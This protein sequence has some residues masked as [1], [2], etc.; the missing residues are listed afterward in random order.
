MA[1]SF[2]WWYPVG[3]Q[4]QEGGAAFRVWAVNHQEVLVRINNAKEH[5]LAPEASGFFSGFVPD[6]RTGSTYNFVLGDKGVFPDPASRFQPEG[7]HGPSQLID[8]TKFSWT[9]HD[10][11]GIHLPGQVIY[12]LHIGTFTREGTW[13]SAI[14]QLSEL[15]S[16][17]ITAIEIM[18][19]NEYAGTFGWGYDG[20]DLY[21]PT[22][23]YG[24][25]DDFR[26][27]VNAAHS[28]G[29]AVLLDVVYNHVGPD[30]NYLAMFSDDYFT[31]EHK[32]DWGEAINFHGK[33]C[34]PVRRFYA[35]NAAYWIKEY[36][37][38]GLRL[39]ATDAIYDSSDPHILADI[40]REARRA[41]APRSIVVVA[42]NEPQHTKLI[43]PVAEGGYGLD[44]LWNDD[45]HHSLIVATI[46]I[47]EGY[48]MDYLGTPQETL[49]CLKYGFLYQGQWYKWQKK[50]RGT[51]TLGTTPSAM[52]TY[53]QNH[54]QIANSG[55]GLRLQ[56][57]TTYGRYKAATAV[58]LL[59][60]GTPMLFQGQEFA[61]SAPFLFFADHEPKLAEL[62]RKGR[63]E[64]LRQWRSLSTC[65][66]AFD[67]PG[68]RE[69]F[70]KCKLDFSEREKHAEV[71]SLHRDLLKLRK[72]EPVFSRQ[73][74]QFDGAILGPE[75]CVFR[76]F[77][78]DFRNDRLLLVNFGPQLFLDPAPVPLLGP[79]EN[80]EWSVLWSSEDPKYGGNGTAPLDSNLNWIIPAH[81][82]VVLQPVSKT[83]GAPIHD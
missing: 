25:P 10:W 49:S 1:L 34:G 72:T 44:G 22:R 5:R 58:C 2:P 51:S 64:F 77:S 66:L 41:A 71:Y 65:E 4:L 69:T 60:P 67:D 38:D 15:A 47:R 59:G 7:P 23:N 82:A 30:G 80:A 29:I 17:G 33:N 75:T 68:S 52:V 16:L 26:S 3:G 79:P 74:R 13:C 42:E 32:T 73:T 19:V 18:P 55:R 43:R 8:P 12:E 9:D 20:V 46:G 45:F 54:D 36:H 35:A 28:H 70:E 53:L 57:L 21:A 24:S 27:F 50:R 11:P 14:E 83:G 78:D 63:A 48:F 56:E 31:P 76:F 6:A 62:V 81:V 61:S 39:D 40:T 37:L